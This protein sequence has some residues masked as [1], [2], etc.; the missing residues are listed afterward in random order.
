MG[1]NNL[2]SH[3]LEELRGGER[4]GPS[5][6]AGVVFPGWVLVLV[7]GLE[8]V[9]GHLLVEDGREGAGDGRHDPHPVR[10]AA[11]SLVLLVGHELNEGLGR[12]VV[13]NESHAGHL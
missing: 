6:V 13:I 7:G 3:L 2:Q 8:V 11:S 9:E 12:S 5:R 10:R 4:I 1:G